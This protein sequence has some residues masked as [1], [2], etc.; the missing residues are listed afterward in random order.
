M[1]KRLRKV[2]LSITALSASIVATFM[3]V[4]LVALWDPFGFAPLDSEIG[5]VVMTGD[6]GERVICFRDNT[7]YT[8]ITDDKGDITGF[9]LSADRSN[10]DQCIRVFKSGDLPFD[11]RNF[12]GTYEA[13]FISWEGFDHENI[14]HWPVPAECTPHYQFKG[15]SH[16]WYIDA[17][18]LVDYIEVTFEWTGTDADWGPCLDARETESVELD[19]KTGRT[20][21]V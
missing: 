10:F 16:P 11:P 14:R 19:P 21:P 9:K 17:L 7:G 2:L 18:G 8:P 3:I 12:I 5:A 13:G 4:A 6:N 15:K 20:M 1:L